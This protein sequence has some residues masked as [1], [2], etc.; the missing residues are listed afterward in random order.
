MVDLAS[1]SGAKSLIDK[2]G[3]RIK[4]GL[5][6]NFLVDSNIVEKIL[7]S[8][9]L[10]CRDTVVEIGP[11]LGVITKAAAARAGKV[12]ALEIDKKLAPL[13]E[14]SLQGF[15]NAQ[16]IY[17]DAMDS[18]IDRIVWQYAGSKGEYKII[19]NLPYY[20]TTPLIMHLLESG[21]NFSLMII[22][23]QLE[24]AQRIAALPGSKEYGAL[25]VAVQYYTEAKFLFKVPKT[26]FMP[27]PEVDSA[28][29]RLVKRDKPAVEVPDEAL[30]FKIIKGAFG[31]RRKTVLNALAA[32]F[33][34]SRD[35]MKKI[36]DLAGIEPSRRGETL[37]LDEFA[38]IA[39]KMH[40]NKPD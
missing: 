2:H 17:C 35:D 6:Q 12:L 40:S 22:M 36:L 11:G 18:D 15:K 5:G 33:D 23:V 38:N 16:V 29:I 19:A 4:K 20:I 1:P 31:Q 39:R 25:S 37:S 3:F 8:A 14:E 34:L 7:S 13:L 27:R 10:D 26:V 28:V 21:F 30:F 9:G 32:A 24:V